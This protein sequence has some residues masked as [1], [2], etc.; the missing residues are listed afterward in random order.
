MH[1]AWSPDGSL[2]AFVSE[3]KGVAQLR[4]APVRDGRRV[5]PPRS[6]TDKEVSASSP[7]WSPDGRTIA[8][9]GMKDKLSELWIVLSD[10]SVPARPITHGVNV[11]FVKWDH[12]TGEILA[13]ALDG[14]GRVILYRVA[15]QD[16]SHQ[17]FQPTVDF[18]GA[19]RYGTF[20]ISTDG[21]FLL[22]S[23]VEKLSG[24][25]GALQA[26]EGHF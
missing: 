4:V 13:S 11:K 3:D 6:L 23:R 10:G 8:F 19:D 1:P 20:E 2:I 22:S 5:G 25:I 12:S 18:G 24:H 9:C 21:R 15:S 26:A 7:A 14:K 17:P 16:G